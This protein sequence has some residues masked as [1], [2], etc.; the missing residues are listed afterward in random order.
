MK[1]SLQPDALCPEGMLPIPTATLQLLPESDVSC[2]DAHGTAGGLEAWQNGWGLTEQA[3]NWARSV[4]WSRAFRVPLGEQGHGLALVPFA[5]QLNHDPGAHIAWHAGLSGY[6]D[7]QMVTF[8]P[9]SQV[10]PLLSTVS[11]TS[12]YSGWQRQVVP[13][14]ASLVLL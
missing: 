12:R 6:E 2:R 3:T 8:A 10:L 1:T 13:R 9:I 11:C 4:V 14:L 7:F 5:D